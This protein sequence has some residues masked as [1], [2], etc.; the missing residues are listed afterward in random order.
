M[1]VLWKHHPSSRGSQQKQ[2]H[3]IGVQATVVV[4]RG[5]TT[6]KG[7][8]LPQKFISKRRHGE[9]LGYNMNKTALA[10]VLVELS[11]ISEEADNK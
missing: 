7:S 2:K 1:T 10:L 5:R 9:V 11:I 6:P 3:W 8:S 4:R